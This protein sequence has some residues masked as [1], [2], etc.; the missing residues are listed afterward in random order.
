MRRVTVQ[1]RRAQRGDGTVVH[2][3]FED[4]GREAAAAVEAEA[5]RLTEWLGEVRI[6]PRFRTPLQAELATG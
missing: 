5:A 6:T 4:V 1:E 3:L 2:R